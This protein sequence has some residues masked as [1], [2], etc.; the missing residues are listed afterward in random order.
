M[1]ILNYTKGK[2]SSRIGEKE[3]VSQSA[4]KYSLN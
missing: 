1:K 4:V 3:L 2:N